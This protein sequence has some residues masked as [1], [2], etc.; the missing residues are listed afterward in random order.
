MK[1]SLGIH[2]KNPDAPP[3]A[4]RYT[5]YKEQM[6]LKLRKYINS[7][8]REQHEGEF[9]KQIYKSYGK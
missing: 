1:I 6:K 7:I 4:K 8:K 5:Y 2:D 9:G 3:H